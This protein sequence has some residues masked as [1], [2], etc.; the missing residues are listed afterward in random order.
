MF[1][2]L[3][4]YADGKP[5]LVNPARVVSISPDR[6]RGALLRIPG[7]FGGS[8]LHVVNSFEK[9]REAVTLAGGIVVAGHDEE[10]G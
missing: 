3:T 8:P 9:V 7:T 1:V 10:E 4:N 6:H 5:L 2:E